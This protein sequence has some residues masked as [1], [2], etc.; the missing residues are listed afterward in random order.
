MPPLVDAWFAPLL[1]D[2]SF[3]GLDEVAGAL[4]RRCRAGAADLG[5]ARSI[6]LD[7]QLA[8]RWRRPLERD[9]ERMLDHDL[10][11]AETLIAVARVLRSLRDDGLALGAMSDVADAAVAR[12]AAEALD[13]ACGHRYLRCYERR[14]VWRLA[15]GDPYPVAQP[16]LRDLLAPA[17]L[18][19]HP[20]R[21]SAPPIDRTRRIALAPDPRGFLLE[22][23]CE[24]VDAVVAPGPDDLVAF[25]DPVRSP[26]ELRLVEV[27]APGG[28]PGFR[29]EPADPEANARCLLSLLDEAL[30]QGARYVLV[31][32]L[33]VGATAVAAMRARL[34]AARH[35]LHLMVCGSAHADVDGLPRNV[36][37]AFLPG[38]RE[39]QHF[40]FSPFDT[41]SAI[42]AIATEPRRLALHLGIDDDGAAIWSF[43]TLICKDFLDPTAIGLLAE[44]R[45]ACVFV[46]AMSLE[47][48]PFAGNAHGLTTVA[49]TLVLVANHTPAPD[50]PAVLVSRP[51]RRD[52]I[53]TVTRSRCGAVHIL[54][55]RPDITSPHG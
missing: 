19:T 8:H 50:E 4:L 47:A 6:G 44:L 29:M 17:R 46:P 36:S 52:P 16:P 1:R 27:P 39:H 30:E 51:L 3:C 23:T 24:H 5:M 41:G 21:L 34:R 20:D 26:D 25:L 33:T 18:S 35:P 12:I 54:A 22:V 14:G 31:P 43:T 49:Q 7:Y 32:E 11:D 45:P 28:R 42:E 53:A 13:T 37:T 38:R 40:K 10:V 55:I 2:R 9:L 48:H 15:G